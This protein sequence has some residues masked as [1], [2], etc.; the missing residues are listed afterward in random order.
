MDTGKNILIDQAAAP[1]RMAEIKS[2]T[3]QF[4]LDMESQYTEMIQSISHSEGDFIEALKIQM[5]KE[6]EI[7]R[8][9]CS[10]FTT[11]I[12]MMQAAETDFGALDAGYA[13]EKLKA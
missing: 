11:L 5:E 9:A 13:Q 1:V 6:L 2:E 3:E 12:E 4:S 8:A 10:F 7:V